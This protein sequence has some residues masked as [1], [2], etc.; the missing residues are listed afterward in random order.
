MD[1][2]ENIAA[3]LFVMIVMRLM[4]RS[5]V[6]Q[7]PSPTLF[8]L[9]S[10]GEIKR[11]SFDKK[12]KKGDIVT[13]L[14]LGLGLTPLLLAGAT[15][16]Y[17]MVIVSAWFVIPGLISYVLTHLKRTTTLVHIPQEEVRPSLTATLRELYIEIVKR[18]HPDHATDIKDFMRRNHITMLA[19][20]AFASSDLARLRD[21][22]TLKQG[23]LDTKTVKVV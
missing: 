3:V 1:G 15:A 22:A 23:N 13:A 16:S 6:S 4:Q 14:L 10:W 20:N 9:P 12:L 5:P 11:W 18:W 2:F 17:E 8:T 21:L 19:N 7:K